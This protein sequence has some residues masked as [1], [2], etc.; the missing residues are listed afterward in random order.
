MELVLTGS[1]D[2][3]RCLGDGRFRFLRRYGDRRISHF[4]MGLGHSRY[5]HM[6]VHMISVSAVL[7]LAGATRIRIWMSGAHDH[8]QHHREHTGGAKDA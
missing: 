6:L 7:G 2:L 5:A 4:R 8:V 1:P 3:N